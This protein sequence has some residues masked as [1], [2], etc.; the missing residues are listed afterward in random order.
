VT[1]WDRKGRIYNLDLTEFSGQL[2][3]RWKARQ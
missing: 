3:P 2:E 1:F